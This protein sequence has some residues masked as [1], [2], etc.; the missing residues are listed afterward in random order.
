MN[1]I[2]QIQNIQND[3]TEK[4]QNLNDLNNK[5]GEYKNRQEVI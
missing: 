5:L 1:I 3:L 4:M 2:E